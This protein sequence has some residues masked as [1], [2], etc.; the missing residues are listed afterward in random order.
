MM[1]FL[2]LLVSI[3]MPPYI[4]FEETPENRLKVIAVYFYVIPN[5]NLIISDLLSN[6]NRDYCV[7]R[8]LAINF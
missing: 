7:F 8:C 6:G 4:K 1:F 2:S 3:K 5:I